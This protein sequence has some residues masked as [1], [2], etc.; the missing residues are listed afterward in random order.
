MNFRQNPLWVN[1]DWSHQPTDYPDQQAGRN[2]V[3]T[4]STTWKCSRLS[5]FLGSPGSPGCWWSN[6]DAVVG[7]SWCLPPP[8]PPPAL[9]PW[10]STAG[11]AHRAAS[12][13]HPLQQNHTQPSQW[14]RLEVSGQAGSVTSIQCLAGGS[15]PHTEQIKALGNWG[16]SFLP[17]ISCMPEGTGNLS[18]TTESTN[19]SNQMNHIFL[20]RTQGLLCDD[21]FSK[22][23]Y[24]MEF[25]LS[26]WPGRLSQTCWASQDSKTFTSTLSATVEKAGLQ[27]SSYWVTWKEQEWGKPWPNPFCSSIRVSR[28][29]SAAAHPP[30]YLQ[31]E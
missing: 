31:H 15:V 18:E 13:C 16:A 11:L 8:V 22:Q 9:T 20:N 30:S 2:L 26:C 24:T 10:S 25:F 6:A 12:P 4:Q 7:H 29:E 27:A 23:P 19:S 3:S 28:Q 1:I 17:G 21:I 5:V 14:Q